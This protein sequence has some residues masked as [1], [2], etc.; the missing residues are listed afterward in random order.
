M[1][2]D[3]LIESEGMNETDKSNLNSELRRNFYFVTLPNEQGYSRIWKNGNG[4]MLGMSSEMTI[5]H[6]QSCIML[7]D[8]NIKTLNEDRFYD[9]KVKDFLIPL[10]K[11]TQKEL[12]EVYQE[13]TQRPSRKN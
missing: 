8:R 4:E 5:E 13:K 2:I 3:A 7:I 1:D 12:K 9:V 6:I 10:A 11:E